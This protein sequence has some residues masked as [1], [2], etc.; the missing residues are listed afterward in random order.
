MAIASADRVHM[1]Y[2]AEGTPGT[3][4]ATPAFSTLRITGESLEVPRENA[5]S[6]ELRSDR[7][8]TDLIQ[9]AGGAGGSIEF[10]LSYGSYDAFLESALQGTWV[11]NVL[12]NGTT[13]KS[14]TLERRLTDL[15]PNAFFRFTG[16]QVN[17]F[18]LKCSAKEIVAGSFDFVGMGG[19]VDTAAINGST[20][21]DPTDSDVMDASTG[22]A[23]FTVTGLSGIHVAS[24]SLDT[25][26]N[27]RAASAAG[28]VEALGVGPGRF[29]LSGSMEVYFE[30]AGIYEAFLDGDAVALSFTLGR[31]TGEKYTFAIPKL[32][33]G[34]GTV[35][36]SGTGNDIMASMGFKGL[37]DPV[38]GCTLMIE[39]GVA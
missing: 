23:A 3:T 33:F 6:S 24:L 14:F 21:A 28:S 32:K 39:R 9:V 11:S 7:N 13:P 22:F 36:A 10:E 26:N 31:T 18:S 35:Q 34:T 5:V 1:A 27:L 37:Y 19:S 12:K 29:E 30:S 2:V 38:N 15:S 25:T 20:C 16:M 17:G 8:V 4:P